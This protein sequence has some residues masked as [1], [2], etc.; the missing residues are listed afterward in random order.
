[1]PSHAGSKIGPEH[2]DEVVHASC[3]AHGGAA[4]LILGASG[5]GKSS[6]ALQ[7]IAMGAKLVADDRTI[8]RRG[9]DGLIADAP[10]TILGQIE[11]RG[12]GILRAAPHG[13]APV[14][15]AIDLDQTETQRL[16]EPREISFLGQSVPLLYFA[17]SPHF[18]ASILQMLACGRVA[19]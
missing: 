7:M 3:V 12:V 5:S 19:L 16:P 17:P 14:R 18:V 8:L 11:A 4:V 6:L 13:P 2:P 9:K 1:M 10:K 15:L